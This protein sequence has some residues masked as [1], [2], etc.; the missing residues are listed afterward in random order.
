MNMKLFLLLFFLTGTV[1]VNAQTYSISKRVNVFGD[2]IET[3]KDR[4][5]KI[6]AVIT[7][8]TDVF[9]SKIKRITDSNGK[10]MR[11]IKKNT[12]IFGDETIAIS[13][14]KGQS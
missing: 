7:H 4:S 5:G 10:E 14:G 2:T 8:S 9:G 12:D 11:S 3:Y 6:T 1:A 13:D